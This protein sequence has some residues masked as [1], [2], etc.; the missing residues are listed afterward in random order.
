M[1]FSFISGRRQSTFADRNVF[2]R[3]CRGGLAARSRLLGRRDPVLKPDSNKDRREWGLLHVKSNIGCQTFSCWSGE[4]TWKG[5]C[6][7]SRRHLTAVQ[8]DDVP[9]KIALALLQ[10]GALR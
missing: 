7:L 3:R 5:R 4:E 1:F 6:Q 10:N 8:N 9:P 2:G